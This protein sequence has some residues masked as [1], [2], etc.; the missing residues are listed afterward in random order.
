MMN[1]LEEAI[2]YATVMHQG[3]V[4]RF[5]HIPYIL[6][7]M[8]VAQVLST[9]TDDEDIITAGILHDVAETD[10]ILT[11]IEKRFGERVAG[12]VGS[13]SER[14]KPDED[15]EATWK[16]RKE[17]ALLVLRNSRD[18]GV[19]MLWLADKLTYIR[20]LSGSYSEKGEAMWR[21]LT[22]KDP[23]MHCWYYK[24]VGETVELSLNKTGAFKEFIK[25]INFIWPGTFDREKAR[26]KKYREVSVGGGRQVG[27]GARGDVDR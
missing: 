26:Y 1:K 14:R 18:I 27:Q 20:L 12:L 15:R 24:S 6:H 7:T 9:M 25:H 2:I 10:S 8:E 19:K 16:R 17:E 3:K 22:Q 23:A 13:V 5:G 21:D 4:H 11:E